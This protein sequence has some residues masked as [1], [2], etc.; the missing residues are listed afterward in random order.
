MFLQADL[1]REQGMLQAIDSGPFDCYKPLGT[2]PMEAQSSTSS[3]YTDSTASV[4]T[5]ADG[6]FEW[7]QPGEPNIVSSSP[8]YGDWPIEALA[9]IVSKV[10][11]SI[12]I[13]RNI[14]DDFLN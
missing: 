6:S 13:Y 11:L 2:M 3:T 5:P 7:S 4:R 1:E 12:S 14:L 9:A 8:V 10:R